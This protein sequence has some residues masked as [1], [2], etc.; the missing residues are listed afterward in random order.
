M[1][2]NFLP[3]C[4][5]LQIL[6]RIWLFATRWAVAHQ[7]PLSMRFS[8][9]KY[10]SWAAISSSR[11]SSQPSVSC[12]SWIAGRFFMWLFLD[13][14]ICLIAIFLSLPCCFLPL[15]LAWDLSYATLGCVNSNLGAKQLKLTSRPKSG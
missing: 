12:V 14:F 3:F 1:P 2:W 11:R 4:V 7:G 9:Q 6:G 8:W 13:F 15:S 10:W 5:L